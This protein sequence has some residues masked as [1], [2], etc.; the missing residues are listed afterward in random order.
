MSSIVYS[1]AS[2]IKRIC[3]KEERTRAH[4]RDL[5][6]FFCLRG[7][8]RKK[9]HRNIMRALNPIV[10]QSGTFQPAQKNVSFPL[11]LTYH[12]G[13]PDLKRLLRQ[14]H[15]TTSFS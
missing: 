4:C 13:L 5:E 1:Q 9:V 12:P 14:F 6:D 10:P 3:S 11:V 2:R 15:P 7:H 8:N